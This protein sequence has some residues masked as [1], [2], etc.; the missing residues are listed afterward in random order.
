MQKQEGGGTMQISLKAARVNAEM[1]Q[2]EAAERI[3]VDVSTVLKWEKGKTS[4]KAV[5]LQKLCEV[6]GV[7]N[8]DSLFLQ[9][10]SS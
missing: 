8:V 2:R 10:K 7:D 1:S 5:Q 4:P 6:Y 9:Q 3:G